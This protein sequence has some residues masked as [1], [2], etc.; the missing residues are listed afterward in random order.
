MESQ[1]GLVE[2]PVGQ[3]HQEALEFTKRPARLQGLVWR[4]HGFKCLNSFD[5]HKR[6]PILP[7]GAAIMRLA[8]AR[9]N[10]H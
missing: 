2:P 8:I 7:V 6:P 5:E 4:L 10:D 3:I 1:D 9:R